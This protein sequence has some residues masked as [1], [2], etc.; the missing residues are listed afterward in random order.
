[1][2]HGRVSTILITLLTPILGY[3]A[4][5]PEPLQQAIQSLGYTEYA[6]LI[7][8]III[9]AYNLLYPHPNNNND[10]DETQN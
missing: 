3:I 4:A 7:I 8:A 10:D 9:T 6:P 1:M 5:N 2:D